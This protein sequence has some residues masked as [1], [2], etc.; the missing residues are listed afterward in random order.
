[1]LHQR[2]AW[3]LFGDTVLAPSVGRGGNLD[4]PIGLISLE[5][6]ASPWST[7]LG[8]VDRNELRNRSRSSRASDATA[9]A[10]DS[11]SRE[12]APTHLPAR[13][14][15]A[16]ANVTRS[17]PSVSHS[18]SCPGG[19]GAVE[20]IERESIAK[21]G[22]KVVEL[23]VSSDETVEHAVKEV[24]ARHTAASTRPFPCVP[25]GL[26]AIMI[27]PANDVCRFDG[28]RGIRR[29]RRLASEDGLHTAMTWPTIGA[30]RP[31]SHQE[32]AASPAS[33]AGSTSRRR[34]HFCHG[35]R[36]LIQDGS[37]S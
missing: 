18:I 27:I 35:L 16:R 33:Y 29:P 5:K 25:I 36:S 34:F 37:Q 21:Q 19:R 28:C 9:S 2:R 8:S 12:N 26:E 3:P 20:E 11:H 23:D 31:E 24:L 32:S 13:R 4:L 15:P 6:L 7:W 1:M 14:E 17:A 10:L 30:L 22:I